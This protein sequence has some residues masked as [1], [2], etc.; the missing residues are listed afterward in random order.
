VRDLRDIPLYT[1]ILKNSLENFAGGT[2]CAYS[3]PEEAF[4]ALASI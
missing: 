2:S 3:A 4:G 1:T